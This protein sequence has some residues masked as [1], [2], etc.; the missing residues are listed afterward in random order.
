MSAQKPVPDWCKETCSQAD[1][2]RLRNSVRNLANQ[3]GFDWVECW[4]IIIDTLEKNHAK[5]LKGRAKS[6]LTLEQVVTVS[7]KQLIE[8]R[9]DRASKGIR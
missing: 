5:V 3:L 9:F 7:L 2:K 4:N 8:E 6:E 1:Y